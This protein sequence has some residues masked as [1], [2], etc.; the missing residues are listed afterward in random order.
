MR[1]PRSVRDADVAGKR[2]LVRADLNV[3]LEDGEV[4]DDTR[5]RA[6]LPTLELLLDRGAARSPSART[7]GGRKAR[8][9]DVRDGAGRGAPAR[10]RCRTS[11][12]DVLENTRFDPGETT[13]D[14][15]SRGE[16]AEGSDLYVNDAFGSAH[17]AHASTEGVAHLL[18]AYAGLLLERRARAARAAARRRR[19]PVRPRR[20]RREGR[21]QARRARA[22]SAGG[23]TRSSSAAR[24][25]SSC[26][27]RI[28]SPFEV[29][30][31]TTSSRPPTFDADAESRVVALRR[32]ARRLARARHRAR[33]ARALR[34]GARVGADGVLERP[35]GRLRVAALRR[36]ARRRSRRR[37]RASDGYTVVGGGD[38]VR[39]ISRARAAPTGSTG[40]RRAAAPRSS[41]S[42][43][44]SFPA[45]RDP[46]RRELMLVAGNWK[47]FKGA[48]R[49]AHV[50]RRRSGTCRSA[51]PASTSSSAR[52]S[53]RSRR[54]V[55]GLGPESAVA[56]SHRTS[57]GSRRG[58][59]PERS[60]RRC[61]RSS[62]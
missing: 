26:A 31:P 60:R 34:R 13:N 44:R 9:P 28:R 52:R 54:R 49:G 17:R 39:A 55:E 10:A 57:T 61:S 32:R 14:P 62:A 27:T 40:C 6:S 12:L 36:R 41:C 46:G 53:S 50:R 56:S 37:S 42:R 23:R 45:S 20:G 38:S 58:R 21:R 22:T 2:V 48:A 47:M 11:A 4:A 18:P 35:D 19:A 3:P 5:I 25:R 33:D 30:L 16:L 15:G 51:S 1:R 29:E 8:D 7:S 43:A 59:S 24:W